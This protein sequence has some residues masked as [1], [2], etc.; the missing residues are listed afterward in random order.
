M[1]RVTVLRRPGESAADFIA[2]CEA[3]GEAGPDGQHLTCWACTVLGAVPVGAPCW[4]L[5]W[6]LDRK[7][8]G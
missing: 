4:L 8:S 5:R 2:R 6:H 3:V 1:A 7:G